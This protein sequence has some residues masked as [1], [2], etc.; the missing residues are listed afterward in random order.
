MKYRLLLET[1]KIFSVEL[2]T[3]EGKRRNYWYEEPYSEIEVSFVNNETC[4][5]NITT[6]D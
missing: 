3:N 4:I 6:G 1:I 2:R 5:S